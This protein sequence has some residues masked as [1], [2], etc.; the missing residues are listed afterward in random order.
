[1]SKDYQ[2]QKDKNIE[3]AIRLIVTIRVAE[4]ILP[5]VIAE[6]KKNL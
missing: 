3:A 5:E 4:L 6:V 2:K 1:M